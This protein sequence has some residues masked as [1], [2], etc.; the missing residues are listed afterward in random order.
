MLKYATTIFAIVFGTSV[1]ADARP[2]IDPRALEIVTESSDFLSAQASAS[3]G[4]V[5]TYDNIIDGRKKHTKVW[6]GSST[7]VR[8][9]GYKSTSSQG[10]RSQQNVYNGSTFSVAY[11][12]TQEYATVEIEGNFR[13]MVETLRDEYAFSIPMA[14]VFDP[15]GSNEALEQISE[16]KY[17]GEVLFGDQVV[18]HVA[19]RRYEG[20]WQIWISANSARPVPV[21]IVGTDPYSLG[22]PQFQALLYD[23]SFDKKM[24]ASDFEFPMPQGYSNIQLQI[25]EGSG[26]GE[27]Q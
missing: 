8:G 1:V 16:A 2:S 27:N 15:S 5:I 22:W 9:V 14:D 21:M 25:V 12:D 6:T 17:L 18:H 26:V 7:L 4:W 3:V 23:W 24:V 20:D 13:A 11:A 10:I 19:F